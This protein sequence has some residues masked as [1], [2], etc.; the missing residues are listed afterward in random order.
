MAK[1]YRIVKENT[2]DGIAYYAQYKDSEDVNSNVWLYV[3]GSS[4][5]TIDV[6]KKAIDIHSDPQ[7]EYIPYTPKNNGNDNKE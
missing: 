6:T 2:I 7:I 4:S 5:K 3:N 1:E